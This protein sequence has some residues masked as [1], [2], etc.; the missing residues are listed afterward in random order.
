MHEISDRTIAWSDTA[1]ELCFCFAIF[2]SNSP[3][4]NELFAWTIVF[5]I[6]VATNTCLGMRV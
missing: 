5:L 6:D 1:L 2:L 4:T 3:S